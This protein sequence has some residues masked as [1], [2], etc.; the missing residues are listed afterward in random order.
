M[1][2]I[3]KTLFGSWLISQLKEKDLSI[4]QLA[5]ELGITSASLHNHIRGKTVPNDNNIRLYADYF[6]VNFWFI[7]DMLSQ[8]R[9]NKKDG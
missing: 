4:G 5:N 8:D 6:S 2:Q 3:P 9:K 7:C 1:T